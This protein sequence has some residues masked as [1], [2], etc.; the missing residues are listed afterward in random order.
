MK[1]AGL[2]VSALRALRERAGLSQK[3]LAA[4]VGISRQQVNRLENG[5][6]DPYLSTVRSLAQ[7][8]GVPLA[9]LVDE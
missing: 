4:Q 1:G 5:S 3:G 8:L 2:R 6:Y 9:E 7:V